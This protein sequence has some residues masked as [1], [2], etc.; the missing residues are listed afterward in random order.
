MS[1]RPTWPP[2]ATAVLLALVGL[3]GVAVALFMVAPRAPDPVEAG[4]RLVEARV[5]AEEHAATMRA[6]AERLS[7]AA[8]TATTEHRDHWSADATSMLADA[9]RLE[10]F[11]LTLR[12]HE[13]ALGHIAGGMTRD[14]RVV[15]AMGVLVASEGVSIAEH[16]RAMTAHAALMEELAPAGGFTIDD[17]RLIA[18]AGAAMTDVGERTRIA[19]EALSASGRLTLRWLGR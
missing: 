15:E 14:P 8:A 16:G 18:S 10:R 11:A 3:L 19:A 9:E 12:N 13:A 17:A 4:R 2:A 1:A 6:S 7:I 5:L